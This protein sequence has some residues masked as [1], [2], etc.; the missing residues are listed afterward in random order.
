MKSIRKVLALFLALVTMLT[1]IPLALGNES[2]V[3][4][5]NSN[6]LK[7]YSEICTP[8]IEAYA[9]NEY[10]RFLVAASDNG[11]LDVPDVVSLGTPFTIAFSQ[12]D[13][14]VYYF[15]I[16]ADGS[17]IATF[18]VYIDRILSRNGNGNVYVGTLSPYFAKELNDLSE[19][20]QTSPVL[21]FADGRKIMAY[22]N[23]QIISLMTYGF[24]DEEIVISQ[25]QNSRSSIEDTAISR[26][27]SELIDYM[28]YAPILSPFEEI[29]S[30]DFIAFQSEFPATRATVNLSLSIIETQGAVNWCGAYATAII[31][32]YLNDSSTAPTALGLM[33]L[34]YRRPVASDSFSTANTTT[35]ASFYGYSPTLVSSS[36]GSQTAFGEIGAGRPIYWIGDD[37]SNPSSRHAMVIRG[38]NT[39]TDTYSIW[40]PWYS[41]YETMD[42]I[43]KTYVTGSSRTYAWTATMYGW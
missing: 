35:V 1:L 8:D 43:T 2:E 20:E 4:E 30:L 26:S 7:L 32:R 39:T 17:V 40:N 38:Y 11:S 3:I 34:V 41:Y 28:R 33:E 5:A 29:A 12:S 15:P 13:T 6:E 16:L 21:I 27:M 24:D 23:N 37:K 31:I 42:M 18:R 19:N 36:I 14:D 25:N 22:E 10:M 9:T